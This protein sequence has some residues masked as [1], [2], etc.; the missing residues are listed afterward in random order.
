MKHS[1]LISLILVVALLS[2]LLAACGGN[3]PMKAAAGTYVG[4]YTKFVGDTEKNT[5]ESFTLTLTGDG[6]G[7]HERDG[8]TLSVT[9]TLDGENFTMQE[10][11]LGMSLDY[12]GTLK[13]GTL[14]IFNGDPTNDLTYEYVFQKQ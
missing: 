3:S 11:F 13:D 8:L 7:T 6:K 2:V 14:D 5:D 1:K 10:T 12:T 9:W 4:Q